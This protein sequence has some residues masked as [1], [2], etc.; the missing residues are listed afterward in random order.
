M[1]TKELASKAAR[2]NSYIRVLWVSLWCSLET[3]LP[4]LVI[5]N[6]GRKFK[7][8]RWKHTALQSDVL[9]SDNPTDLKVILYFY[10]TC[11]YYILRD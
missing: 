8:V 7:S 9:A 10:F 2:R 6:P 1:E 3:T 4:W 11:N 5:K